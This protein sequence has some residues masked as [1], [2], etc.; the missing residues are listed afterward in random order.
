MLR[1]LSTAIDT[2]HAHAIDIKYRKNCYLN[3]VTNVLCRLEG[4]SDQDR[5]EL[6][7]KVQFL[8]IIKMALREG[9]P[10]D[11]AELEAMYISFLRE[12]DV[13]DPPCPRK[14]LLSSYMF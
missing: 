4:S 8:D 9:K 5:G 6:A 12:N 2:Y 14:A 13:A 11:M 7:A 3:N 1:K 10:L